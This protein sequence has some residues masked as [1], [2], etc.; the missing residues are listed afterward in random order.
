[1]VTYNLSAE[2]YILSLLLIDRTTAAVAIQEEAFAEASE[3]EMDVRLD[4]GL[5]GLLSKKLLEMDNESYKLDQHFQEY[6]FKMS[7]VSRTIKFQVAE[8][9]SVKIVSLFLGEQVDVQIMENN[10]RVHT[11]F[12]LYD[13]SK[14]NNLIDFFDN[15]DEKSF[16]MSEPKFDQFISRLLS[17]SEEF[18]P[19]FSNDVPQEFVDALV[20]NKGQLNSIFDFQFDN[21]GNVNSLESYLYLTEKNKTWSIKQKDNLLVVFVKPLNQ[22]LK[23]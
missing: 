15:T 18:N 23:L 19:E 1:M 22:V 10:S 3:E 11:F 14:V 5:N 8:G 20:K 17:G 6:L 9:K 2:E 4:S 16:T 21:D 7:K 13:L 12:T